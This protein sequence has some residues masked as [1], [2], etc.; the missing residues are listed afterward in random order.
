MYVVHIQLH[1]R[2]AAELAT[3]KEAAAAAEPALT[4]AQTEL[5]TAKEAAAA[6]AA[7][8]ASA[9]HASSPLIDRVEEVMLLPSMCCFAVDGEESHAGP[10]GR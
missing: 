3:A 5:A 6:S 2:M 8:L 7:E 4:A 10:E 9:K 1:V